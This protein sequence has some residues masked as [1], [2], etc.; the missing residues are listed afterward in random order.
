M[1]HVSCTMYG[2]MSY[3]THLSCVHH[4]W[5]NELWHTSVMTHLLSYRVM[6]AMTRSFTYDTHMTDVCHDSF[7]HTWY[8][9]DRYVTCSYL[10]C[11][12][13]SCVCVC[14][15][16]LIVHDS[17]IHMWYTHDRYVPWLIHPHMV[18]K[19]HMCA[20]FTSIVWRQIMCL[21]VWHVTVCVTCALLFIWLYVWY[22][23]F[24]SWLIHSHMIHTWQMCAMTHPSTHGTRIPFVWHVH[25]YRVMTDHVSVCVTCALLF[26]WLCVWHDLIV[27]V[28]VCVTYD[29]LLIYLCVWH[30]PYCYV[31]YDSSIYVCHH[32]F[33]CVGEW[34]MAPICQDSL[35]LPPSWLHKIVCVPCRIVMCDMSRSYVWHDLLVCVAWLVHMR[36]KTH[37]YVQLIHIRPTQSIMYVPLQVNGFVK[38][39]LLIVQYKYLKS[40]SRDF[41]ST[42]SDPPHKI[43]RYWFYYTI[44]LGFSFPPDHAGLVEM[45]CTTV[46]PLSKGHFGGASPWI[47]LHDS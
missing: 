35:S 12:D 27:H 4:L 38:S 26:I 16:C 29:L 32:W 36:G 25:I 19:W 46:V 42:E 15:M 31:W 13:R 22:A 7:I 47:F 41:C 21:C 24:C 18:H 43:M 9:N 45:I 5:T 39:I 2:W 23:S 10:S 34:V 20:M 40:C 11:D 17:F 28:T 6:S 8:T 37:S 30:V 1:T 3:G 33:M 14:D 44:W